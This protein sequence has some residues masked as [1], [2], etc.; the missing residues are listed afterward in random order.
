MKKNL[1]LLSIIA[2]SVILL[3]V[4]N[5]SAEAYE[6]VSTD[7]ERVNVKYGNWETWN[8]SYLTSKEFGQLRLYMYYVYTPQTNPCPKCKFLVKP[9]NVDGDYGEGMSFQLD[10]D[11]RWP[12]MAVGSPGT[13][14]L[15]GTRSDWTIDKLGATI[16]AWF[17]IA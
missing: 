16:K 9:Y 17:N 6:G 4:R 11:K 13:Y 2:M 7:F 15:R 1:K 12:T 5:V 14:Y 3:N 8:E 10:D